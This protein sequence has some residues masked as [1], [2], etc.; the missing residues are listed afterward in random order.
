MLLKTLLFIYTSEFD[1]NLKFITTKYN[2]IEFN[3]IKTFA[4]QYNILL[5]YMYILISR[6]FVES[7]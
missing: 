1:K 7:I 5:I 3:K 2:F 6:D 4:I